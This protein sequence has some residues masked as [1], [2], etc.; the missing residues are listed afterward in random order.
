MKCSGLLFAVAPFAVAGLCVAVPA[1]AQSG[2]TAS[3][4]VFKTAQQ[5]FDICTS[6]DSA[7]LESCDWFIMASHDMI[8]FYGDTNTGGEKICVPADS[9]ELDVRNTVIAYW[10]GN[11]EAMRYSAVST[12]YNALIQAY[13]C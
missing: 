4:G 6:E 1:Q 9:K 13:P 3:T 2:S 11:P 8:K 5:L 10:R 7:D 12:I